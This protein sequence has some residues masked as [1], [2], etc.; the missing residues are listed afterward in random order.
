MRT[1]RGFRNVQSEMKIGVA[2]WPRCPD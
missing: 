2:L 1:E